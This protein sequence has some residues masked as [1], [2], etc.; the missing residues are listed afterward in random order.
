MSDE[1]RRRILER[2]AR[3]VTAAIASAGLAACRPCLSIEPLDGDARF[4]AGG[5]DATTQ[6]D[7]A[8]QV[9]AGSPETGSPPP[10]PCLSPVPADTGTQ[11]I[12]DAGSQGSAADAGP[13]PMPCLKIAPPKAP[14]KA[15]LDVPYEP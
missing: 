7:A 10:V 1:P 8:A 5:A 6:P 3:F 15:C 4:D 13:A 12:P 9:D 11:A 14:P 2:R